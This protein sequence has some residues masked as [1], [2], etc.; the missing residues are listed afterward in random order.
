MPPLTNNIQ[1]SVHDMI[2]H[3]LLLETVFLKSAKNVG[4]GG[5]IYFNTKHRTCVLILH[6]YLQ[7][8][9]S[10]FFKFIAFHC[11]IDVYDEKLERGRIL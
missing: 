2:K 5:Y 1:N 4:S 8:S 3:L 7:F 6:F 11:M 10:L 9:I